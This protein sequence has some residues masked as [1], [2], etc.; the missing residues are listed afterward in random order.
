MH[1]KRKSLEGTNFYRTDSLLVTDTHIKGTVMK[2]IE[3]LTLFNKAEYHKRFLELKFGE[4]YCYFY[5][6]QGKT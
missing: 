6:K 3:N 5:E 1:Q 2:A 4:Q